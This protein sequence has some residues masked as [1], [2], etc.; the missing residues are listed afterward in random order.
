MRLLAS[1]I[2]KVEAHVELRRRYITQ[3]M[4]PEL[5]YELI[6]AA[7]DNEKAAQEVKVKLLLNSMPEPKQNVNKFAK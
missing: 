5:G 7:Y 1:I 2:P 4:T 3:P 6:K